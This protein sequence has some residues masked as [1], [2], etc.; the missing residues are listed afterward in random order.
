MNQMSK[1]ILSE[2]RLLQKMPPGT[3]EFIGM[4]RK[5][6]S[7][8]SEAGEETKRELKESVERLRSDIRL[9]RPANYPAEY[10]RLLTILSKRLQSHSLLSARRQL[11][12]TIKAAERGFNTG[13]FAHHPSFYVKR[14]RYLASE[15]R[16]FTNNEPQDDEEEGRELI[17]AADETVERIKAYE[18][19]HTKVELSGSKLR[20]RSLF[21]VGPKREAW[22]A[23]FISPNTE[24]G[25]RSFLKR[26]A[27]AYTAAKGRP[28]SRLEIETGLG[29]KISYF[30]SIVQSL[31]RKYLIVPVPG[32]N[33]YELTGTGKRVAEMYIEMLGD[34][35]AVERAGK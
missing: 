18:Y 3:P 23:E 6:L 24:Y 5:I 14:I 35:S 29:E 20:V 34:Q 8:A 19:S 28:L 32:E 9:Y 11:E 12:E 30:P 17:Q 10:I 25:G 16:L 4:Q 21:T 26:K 15:I 33:K 1:K 31:L 7:D 27:L 22:T 2:L 13:H